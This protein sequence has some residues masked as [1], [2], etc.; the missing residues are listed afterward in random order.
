[1]STSLILVVVVTFAFAA[2]RAL[3]H[4]LSRYVSLSGVEYLFVGLLMGPL[5]PWKVLTPQTLEHLQPLVQLLTGLLG[6]LLGVEGRAAFRKSGP[7]LV[8]FGAA[9][10]VAVGTACCIL[11]AMVWLDPGYAVGSSFTIDREI[12]RIDQFS[13]SL[14]IP[15]HLLWASLIIGAAAA[16]ASSY[17]IGNARKLFGAQGPVGELLEASSRAGQLAGVF[18]LG[19]VL[20][21]ARAAEAAT[22]FHLTLTEWE[23]AAIGLGIVCG[24]LFGLF[25]GRENDPGR[26][27]LA[28][29]GLVTFAAGTGSAVGISPIF[30]TMFAGL[31]VSLTSPHVDILRGHLEKLLHPLFVL[32][33]VFAGALWVPVEAELWLLVPIFVLARLLFRR[34][35]MNTLAFTFLDPPPSTRLL[36]SGL[37]APGT[38]AVA[39][40]VSGALRFPALSPVILSCVIVGALFSELFSHRA[41]RRLLDDAGE[42][43]VPNTDS[44]TPSSQKLTAPSA[45]GRAHS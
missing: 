42:V 39:I 5:M 45:K 19:A 20:A 29:V 22:Q 31:T 21:S 23:L 1:M 6:F 25:L 43:A 33:M 24:L 3:T 26:I 36:G 27:F 18:I 30:V 8:G 2:G 32:L 12:F 16:S 35:T 15:S 11:P 4:W 17:A 9:I 34:I 13:F 44:P 37:W 38:L 14:F 40:A 41:L 28:S 10:A 7:A